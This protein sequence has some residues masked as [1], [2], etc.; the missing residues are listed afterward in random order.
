MISVNHCH[1]PGYTCLCKQCRSRWVGFFRSQLI[2]I[3]TVCHQVCEF[4]ATIQIKQSDWLKIRSGCGIL[5]Y[6]AGQG[7]SFASNSLQ[8]KWKLMVQPH[9]I[10]FNNS[11]EFQMCTINN[12]LWGA[13]CTIQL[14]ALCNM[15]SQSHQKLT[16]TSVVHCGKANITPYANGKTPTQTVHLHSLVR[17][18]TICQYILQVYRIPLPMVLRFC[19][20]TELHLGT[21]LYEAYHPLCHVMNQ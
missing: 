15:T 18:F 6:S 20:C 2:W 1:E 17:V 3:C 4:I 13:I 7:L 12:I 11:T 5:I 16:R 21:C 10:N 14:Y 19:P 8:V 9:A